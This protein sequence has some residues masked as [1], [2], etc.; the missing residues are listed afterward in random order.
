M[1][2]AP[3]IQGSPNQEGASKGKSD[4]ANPE[5]LE[6]QLKLA[7]VRKRQSNGAVDS[8]SGYGKN[9]TSGNCH[10]KDVN[11]EPKSDGESRE[12][13][14]RKKGQKRQQK[15]NQSPVSGA[16]AAGPLSRQVWSLSSL[17]VSWHVFRET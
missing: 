1:K 10:S 8:D 5:E 17:K 14:P 4:E 12:P 9:S 11:L 7:A 3:C 2:E 16:E 6:E 13:S 15:E